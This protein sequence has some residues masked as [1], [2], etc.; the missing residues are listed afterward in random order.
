[1]NYALFIAITEEITVRF[2]DKFL[3]NA[4]VFVFVKKS[5]YFC[6]TLLSN[7]NIKT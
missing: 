2:R 6:D 1:M 4:W 3:R 7:S 5:N